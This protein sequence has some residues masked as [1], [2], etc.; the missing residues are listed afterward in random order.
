LIV[1]TVNLSLAQPGDQVRFVITVNN[2]G[3][4]PAANTTVVDPIPVP[5][6]LLSATTAQGTFTISGN[7]VTFNLGAV[8]PG[9]QIVMTITTQVDP[10]AKTPQSI[11]NTATLDSNKNSSAKLRIT[12]GTLPETGEH[13][14]D[15]SAL[16]QPLIGALVALLILGIGAGVAFRRRNAN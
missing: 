12:S 15:T 3:T 9:Q 11:T 5:L 4:A 10:K 13:P 2:D 1:K 7:T 14:A 16:W 8:N 6:I